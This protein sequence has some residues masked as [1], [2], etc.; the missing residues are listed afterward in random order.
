MA[1]N[2]NE[3]ALETFTLVR[4]TRR[5]GKINTVLESLGTAML[6]MWALK[7]TRGAEACLIFNKN[8]GHV[9]FLTEGTSTGFPKISDA[10]DEDL[11]HIDDYCKGLLKAIQ[12]QK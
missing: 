1:N 7:N 10:R 12:D 5:T 3:K 2:P 4:F 11:G 8:N 6:Q 9:A